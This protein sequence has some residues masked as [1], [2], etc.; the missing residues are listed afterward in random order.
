ML[1]RRA[2]GFGGAWLPRPGDVVL[3]IEV[4]DTSL[5][6]DWEVK[7]PRYAA[8]AIPEAWLVDLEADTITICRDPG[9]EGYRDVS[10]VSRGDTLQPENLPGTTITA[11]EIL[12]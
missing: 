3:L 2:E 7:F 8:A 9:P 6:R 10:T 11:D 4:A 12:G 5:E 1:L